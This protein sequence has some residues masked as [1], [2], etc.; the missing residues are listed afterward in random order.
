MRSLKILYWSTVRGFANQD[1]GPA[2]IYY[3]K[4]YRIPREDFG[5]QRGLNHEK[6]PGDIIEEIRNSRPDLDP[7]PFG[8]I[9]RYEIFEVGTGDVFVMYRIPRRK[10]IHN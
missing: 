1:G 9:E 5:T 3:G 7:S 6:D 8:P 2:T 4:V 10:A